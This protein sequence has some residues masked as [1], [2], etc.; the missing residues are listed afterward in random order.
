MKAGRHKQ[1]DV[2]VMEGN[3]MGS[4]ETA[5]LQRKIE[6]WV[7]IGH[8]FSCINIAYFSILYQD[9]RLIISTSVFTTEDCV[10]TILGSLARRLCVCVC[11]CVHIYMYIVYIYIYMRVCVFAG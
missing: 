2:S 10:V 6:N 1:H 11:V 8:T 3:P 5:R 4:K 7:F 9:T